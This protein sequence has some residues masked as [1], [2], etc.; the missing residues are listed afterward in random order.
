MIDYELSPLQENILLALHEHAIGKQNAVNGKD[1]AFMVGLNSSE[2][3]TEL[4]AMKRKGHIIGSSKVGYWLTDEAGVKEAKS[5][6]YNK[7]AGHIHTYLAMFPEETKKIHALVGAFGNKNDRVLNG[8]YD[9]D[10]NVVEKY[11]V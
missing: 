2:L 5:Y 8:Q 4:T 11:E 3:R 10:D 6:Q 1:L 9:I 7:L